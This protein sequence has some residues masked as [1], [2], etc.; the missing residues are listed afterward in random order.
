MLKISRYSFA[1][2]IPIIFFLC[3][4]CGKEIEIRQGRQVS[5]ILEE[6]EKL[7]SQSRYDEAVGLAFE[8]LRI[9]ENGEEDR[10]N[11]SKSHLTLS[12]LF[13]QTS[14]DS[15]S[16]EHADA[17]EELA[18][19][20]RNDSLRAAA[21]LLKGKI[22][23]YA[24]ISA[25]SN[26]DDEGIGYLEEA[27]NLS[28]ANRWDG[29]SIEACYFLCE[30]YVNKNRFNDIIDRDLYNKAGEWLSRA[31]S[32]DEGHQSARALS[33]RMRY[34]RQGDKIDEAIA[35]CNRVLSD[36]P[37]SDYLKQ[38]QIYDHLTNLYLKKRDISKATEAHQNYSYFMQMYMRQK[39]DDILQELQTEY[40]TDLKDRQIKSRTYWAF[41]LGV[42]LL[43]ALA[44][45]VQF[46]RLNKQITSKNKSIEAIARSR[47]MLFAVIAKDLYDPALAG[48]K[49]SQTLDFIRKWPTMSEDEI[50][51]RCA[52]LAEGDAPMDPLVV[53]Y[54]SDLMFSR[55]KSLG[56]R[57]LSS[58]ELEIIS[59]SKEGLS[60][61]QIA[62]KLFLS[63][64][65][66]SN[67]KYRIYSK[68][69]VSGNSEMLAKA[70]ELGL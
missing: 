52:S 40:Q 30:I 55:K 26:R 53:N 19:R 65:T 47:E 6:A 7:T 59:L 22:C 14:R 12:K 35:F 34:L 1:A 20:E 54:I 49:D 23:S 13:L 58:R 15:L 17:A 36:T 9:S 25:E 3:Q 32:L 61:K 10:I 41:L 68:L 63:P 27:L 4:S 39:G 37:E 69:E 70:E 45:I 50:R 56:T 21:L 57:G 66:V 48:I 42:F 51:E 44:A 60:D 28:E 2:W 5:E 16:W 46:I 18:I 43:L 33:T 8:A 11:Q 62:D 64:R 29:I 67:H 38:Y 31:E 24:T